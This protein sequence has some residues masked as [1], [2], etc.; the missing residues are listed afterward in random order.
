MRA[1]AMLSALS[2]A[3][4]IGGWPAPAA[5]AP[6]IDPS[7]AAVDAAAWKWDYARDL[8]PR[9]IF[10]GDVIAPQ[11]F[12]GSAKVVRKALRKS[13]AAF[14]LE[15]S[16]AS[17]AEYVL[18]ASVFEFATTDSPRSKS[19]T[20][21]IGIAYQIVD[22]RTGAPLLEEAIR[23]EFTTRAP[24]KR[25]ADDMNEALAKTHSKRQLMAR[26]AA[27]Q[28]N[29]KPED[30]LSVRCVAKDKAQGPVGDGEISQKARTVC[31]QNHA[32]HANL[33]AFFARLLVYRPAALQASAQSERSPQAHR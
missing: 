32:V 15:S 29:A 3:F 21:H 28:R 33:E 23:T 13:L 20:A 10:V 25:A 27:E 17:R 11:E 1:P 24:R 2:A 5:S 18:S 30:F 14:A 16:D 4:L 22:A 12:P 7:F 6:A 31:A 9:S 8:G 26:L 19:T